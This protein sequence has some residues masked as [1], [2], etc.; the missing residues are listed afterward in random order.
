[1]LGSANS[2]EPTPIS[3]PCTGPL[4]DP[5]LDN[6]AV[7]RQL[8]T[9]YESE[10]FESLETTMSCL[11][12]S[13][14]RLQSGHSGPG[15]VYAF[16]RL[17]MPT[18]GA[19]IE[20]AARVDRWR[21]E[22]PKSLFSEFAD[23]R[24]RYALAWTA[25]GGNYAADVAAERW[26]QFLVGIADAE[27]GLRMASPRLKET[28]L[29]QQ[30]WLVTLQDRPDSARSAAEAFS[31]GV[32]KWPHFYDFYEAAFARTTPSW[33]GSWVQADEFAEK[34]SRALEESEGDSLYA[35]L[36]LHL[37]WHGTDPR[38]TNAS[39]PRLR[40]S[41]EDLVKRYP[42]A[43]HINLAASLACLYSD[44]EAF[45]RTMS[46]IPAIMPSVWLFGTAFDRCQSQLAR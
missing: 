46:V 6:F 3:H 5:S 15:A 10:R 11:M 13:S 28:Q 2:A 17:Q 12:R 19:R 16:Y 39:W 23:L 26:R 34:W 21:K 7:Y 32:R 41:L 8:K 45:N 36:Y 44:R 30:L 43:L 42:T 4:P 1:M 25:R 38:K 9:L 29:W 27:R 31:E 24:L 33:R 40:T 37:V 14:T 18:P 20:E 35:R 22:K